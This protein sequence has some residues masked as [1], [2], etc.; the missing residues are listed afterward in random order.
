MEN[1]YLVAARSHLGQLGPIPQPLISAF[2]GIGALWLGCKL[3]SYLRLFLSAFI[4]SGHNVSRY[5]EA[6]DRLT[7]N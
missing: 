6:I 7:R 3:F 2:A 4:F 1:P 5:R